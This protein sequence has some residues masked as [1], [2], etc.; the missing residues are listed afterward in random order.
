M[1]FKFAWVFASI[2]SLLAHIAV[3]ASVIELPH[4]GDNIIGRV[5]TLESKRGDTLRKIGRRYDIGSAEMKDAN[6]ELELDT[7]LKVGTQVVIPQRFILPGHTRKGIVVNI[8]ELR[9]YYFLDKDR[10]LTA[11]IGIGR[12]GWKTPIGT[13]K[14]IQKKYKPSWRP[15]VA[16]REEERKKGNILPDVMPPGPNNPLGDYMMRLG[17]YSYLIHSTNRP[18]GVGQRVTSGCILMY[19]EDI[20]KIFPLVP[21][22]TQVTIV[23]EPIKIGH[24][25]KK[26][27]IEV[28][29]PL[30]ERGQYNEKDTI[31]LIEKLTKLVDNTPVHVRWKR[32]LKAIKRESGIPVVVGYY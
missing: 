15:P 31:D 3:H 2:L 7:S 4:N 10:V 12:V 32:A 1:K 24:Q 14:I 20:E 13:T 6:P 25:G 8:S 22:G 28:H 29:K 26:F 30:E 27:F 19:P 21:L 9:M 23:D 18:A 11:P 16:V 5:Q 17:W